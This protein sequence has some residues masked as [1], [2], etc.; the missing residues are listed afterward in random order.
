LALKYAERTFRDKET[1]KLGLDNVMKQSEEA[2]LADPLF[3]YTPR[4]LETV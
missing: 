3:V 1:A 2:R 4:Y